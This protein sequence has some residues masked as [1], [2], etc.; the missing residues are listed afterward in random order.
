MS[1]VI[2]VKGLS[3]YAMLPPKR[4]NKM[5]GMLIRSGIRSNQLHNWVTT[6]QSMCYMFGS[7][8]RG[9]DDNRIN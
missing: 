5:T 3:R 2:L 6:I 8:I 9:V 4:Y 7:N 1:F